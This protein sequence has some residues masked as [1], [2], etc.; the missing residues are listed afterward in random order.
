MDLPLE[1]ILKDFFFCFTSN[2]DLSHLRRSILTSGIQTPL[3]VLPAR[4]GYRLLSG[5][6]RFELALELGLDRIPAKVHTGKT[7]VEKIFLEVILE[8][9]SCHSLNL[10]EKARIIRILNRLGVSWELMEKEFLPMMDLP[11]RWEIVQEVRDI[12]ALAPTVQDYIQIYNLSF[13]Q[14]LVFAEFTYQQQELL[15][16]L[17]MKLQIRG[18]E[19]SEIL[20]LLRDI[21][22]RD[23]ISVEQILENM[24]VDRIIDSEDL[25]RN[26]KIGQVK[27]YLRKRRYPRL[28]SW[29]ES[30]ENQRREMGLPRSLQVTW[31]R[32]LERPG[33]E[34]R[35][36]IK[37][38]EDLQRIIAQLSKEE[39]QKRFEDM[40]RTV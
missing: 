33:I 5:F 29:N 7:H 26:E 16:R 40:L 32:S 38:V 17:G 19:L 34:L 8:H 28:T 12:L 6:K 4:R 23:G 22:K 39:N 10:L 1:E 13:K 14:T 2:S 31:D 21:T 30:L 11:D 35:A 18:V 25:S 24:E 3:H 9:L 36:E 20:S 15:I 27:E 37:S